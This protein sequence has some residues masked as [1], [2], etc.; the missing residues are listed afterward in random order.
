MRLFVAI[1]LPDE[2]QRKV[3]K[4][5]DLVEGPWKRDPAEK[6]HITLKFIGEVDEKRFREIDRALSTIKHP[7][8]GVEVAGIGAFPSLQ[9][10]RV[11]WVGAKGEGLYSLQKEVEEALFSLGIPREVREFVP[12]VT[13]GRAKGKVDIS[14]LVERF[15]EVSFG[16]FTA[17]ELAL[18]RSYL[19]PGGSE[20]E[21]IRRYPL[22]D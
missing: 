12:H 5:G 15:S 18:V 2:L 3:W 16:T 7:P 11:I 17:R 20:Y 6:L 13:L 10:P 4:V 22:E 19:K 21:I 1:Y 9:R 14:S 8:F